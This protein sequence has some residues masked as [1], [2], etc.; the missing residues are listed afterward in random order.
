MDQRRKPKRL[1]SKLLAIRRHFG[2][3]QTGMKRLLNYPGPYGRL[4]E[5]ELNKRQPDVITT[6]S[7]AR[8][9]RVPMDDLIDDNVE[10]KL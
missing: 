1:A 8:L 10:L 6:L 9:A 3:S 7:Y 4:S 5:W 2:V